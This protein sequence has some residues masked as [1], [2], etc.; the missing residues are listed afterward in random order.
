MGWLGLGEEEGST[1]GDAFSAVRAAFKEDISLIRMTWIDAT[2]TSDQ[3]RTA[4]ADVTEMLGGPS[5]SPDENRTVDRGFAMTRPEV[6]RL[7]EERDREAWQHA[8]CLS[9]AEGPDW[10]R[11]TFDDSEAMRAVRR[12][13]AERDRLLAV[14]VAQANAWDAMARCVD[15]SGWTAEAVLV[16]L[17]LHVLQQ[18]M[19]EIVTPFGEA[20]SAWESTTQATEALGREFSH[21]R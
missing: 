16:P 18:E 7:R 4:Q 6:K 3:R 12:L 19:A 21:A 13:R 15:R 8:G 5:A 14:V 17:S 11:P 9:I 2:D 1:I 10:D 20:H